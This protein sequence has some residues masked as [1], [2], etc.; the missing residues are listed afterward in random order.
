MY[1]YLWADENSYP[2]YFVC[3]EIF[4]YISKFP[5]VVKCNQENLLWNFSFL[6]NIN[7]GIFPNNYTY[8]TEEESNFLLSKKNCLTSVRQ[9]YVLIIY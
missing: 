7:I 5:V 2:K 8:C 9:K 3:L 1:K 6:C 4:K